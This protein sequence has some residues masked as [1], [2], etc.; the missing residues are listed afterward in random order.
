MNTPLALTKLSLALDTFIQMRTEG[1]VPNVVNFAGAM[2]ACGRAARWRMALSLMKELP[3]LQLEADA[4][5]YNSL[6]SAC[7]RASEWRESLRLFKRMERGLG[8]KPTLVTYGALASA[9]EK[10][11]QWLEALLLLEQ[12]PEPRTVKGH[13]SLVIAFNTVISACEKAWRWPFA[14]QVFQRM[15]EKKLKPT[16]ITW[17]ALL[18]AIRRAESWQ[19]SL[20]LFRQMQ[21]EDVTPILHTYNISISSCHTVDAWPYALALMEEARQCQSLFPDDVTYFHLISTACSSVAWQ[22]A[23]CFLAAVKDEGYEVEPMSYKQVFTACDRASCW[24]AALALVE[25]AASWLDR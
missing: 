10:G 17:N 22:P 3:G 11:E 21:A 7:S 16:T 18:S 12:L 6:I 4:A 13:A 20:H 25:E 8:P 1:L 5:V 23:L 15:E 19:T 14:L 24:T 9:L 2:S